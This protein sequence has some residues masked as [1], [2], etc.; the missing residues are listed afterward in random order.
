MLV[1]L[2]FKIYGARA[3]CVN[4]IYDV[5]HVGGR[6]GVV[7]LEKD[8]PQLL[9]RDVAVTFAEITTYYDTCKVNCC[10]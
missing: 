8:F 10:N 3:V 5:V 9:S 1:G 7:Q 4:L 6:D 2:T